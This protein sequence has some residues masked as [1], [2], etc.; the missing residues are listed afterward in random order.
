MAGE[1]GAAHVFSPSQVRRALPAMAASQSRSRKAPDGPAA[2]EKIV[3]A[4]IEL[5]EAGSAPGGGP[6]MAAVEVTT[7]TCSRAIATAAPI[8]SCS[9]WAGT[10]GWFSAP[11]GATDQPCQATGY[12]IGLTQA[13]GATLN[14]KEEG[15]LIGEFSLA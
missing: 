6:G 14:G 11:L 1:N 2:E 13:D 9:P 3:A 15:F 5:M 10:F 4:L 12:G 8:R 7:S